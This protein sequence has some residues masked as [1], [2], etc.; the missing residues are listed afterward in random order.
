VAGDSLEVLGQLDPPERGQLDALQ[1]GD[2]DQLG[3]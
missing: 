3:Q 2:A 1:V